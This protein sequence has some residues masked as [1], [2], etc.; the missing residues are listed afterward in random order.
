MAPKISGQYSTSKSSSRR[1]C[2]SNRD[3]SSSEENKRDTGDIILRLGTHCS[4]RKLRNDEGFYVPGH[5]LAPIA[6]GLMVHVWLASIYFVVIT[7]I[8]VLQLISPAA[9]LV[10]PSKIGQV[11]ERNEDCAYER[12]SR[13]PPLLNSGCRAYVPVASNTWLSTEQ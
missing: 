13:S 11:R 1:A 5:V 12:E 10:A 8:T 4:C 9:K 7:A 3:I 2:P 6:C